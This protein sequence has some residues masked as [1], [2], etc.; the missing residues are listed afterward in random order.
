MPVG[1]SLL[2]AMDAATGKVE[3]LVDAGDQRFVRREPQPDGGQDSRY[4]GKQRH[5][6]RSSPTHQNHEVVRVRNNR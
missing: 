4:F 3:A 6:L 1:A 2:V 5:G